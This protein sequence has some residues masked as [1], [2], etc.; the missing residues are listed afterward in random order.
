M[1]G[2]TKKKKGKRKSASRYTKHRLEKERRGGSQP[3]LRSFKVFHINSNLKH[4]LGVAKQDFKLFLAIYV[5]DSIMSFDNLDHV[6]FSLR[7]LVF[8]RIDI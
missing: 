8:L 2:A 7:I 3:V 4:K 1:F 6:S 5:D